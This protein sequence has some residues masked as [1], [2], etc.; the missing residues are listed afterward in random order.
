MLVGL[1]RLGWLVGSIFFRV[2]FER[3]SFPLPSSWCL[4]RACL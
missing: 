1:L 3:L 4:L 2:H